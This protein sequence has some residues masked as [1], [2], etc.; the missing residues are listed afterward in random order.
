MIPNPFWDQDVSVLFK[1]F[2]MLW[3]GIREKGHFYGRTRMTIMY[4]FLFV[5]DDIANKQYRTHLRH[6]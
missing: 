1:G 6:F 4:F 3:T 5:L 2:V